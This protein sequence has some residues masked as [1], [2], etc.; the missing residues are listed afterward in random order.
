MK[1]TIEH[2]NKNFN[3]VK[4]LQD[5][6]W[7]IESKKT[8]VILGSN[9]SGKSTLM[10]IIAG[11]MLFNSGNIVYELNHQTISSDDIWQHISYTAPYID[12]IDEF[13]AL[14][15]LQFHFKFKQLQ[16]FEQVS[17]LLQYLSLPEKKHI[18]YFSSGMKMKLKL[19]MSF[20]AK[21]DILLLDEPCSHFDVH[22]KNWYKNEIE[23]IQGSK[24]ILIASNDK[25]EYDF[26]NNK[27]EYR[28][29]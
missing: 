7:I 14:E 10:Q 2:L 5:I 15:L 18:K 3:N 13:T 24:T 12:I 16:G 21:S 6:H 27:I 17:H 22:N 25:D 19:A 20:Y 28:I 4:V 11:K 26:N 8:G 9:G 29:S 23:K 1:I